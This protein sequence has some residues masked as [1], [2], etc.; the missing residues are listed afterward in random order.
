MC[1]WTTVPVSRNCTNNNFKW[2]FTFFEDTNPFGR[3]VS[4][5]A[6]LSIVVCW[7]HWCWAERHFRH[8]RWWPWAP[9]PYAAGR[10]VRSVRQTQIH[11]NAPTA[12]WP[13]TSV[14]SERV[15]CRIDLETTVHPICNESPSRESTVVISAGHVRTSRCCRPSPIARHRG[16]MII[17]FWL[18]STGAF[19]T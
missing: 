1:Q 3:N 17:L 4:A 18:L 7:L 12:Q 8:R 10:P 14:F 2:L 16:I 11:N 6:L 13:R 5:R 15:V 9:S 19:I